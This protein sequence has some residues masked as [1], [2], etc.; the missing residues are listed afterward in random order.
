MNIKEDLKKLIID[1]IAIE[2]IKQDD[3]KDDEAVFEEG[4]GVEYSDALE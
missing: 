3:I 2:E 4:L 1:S